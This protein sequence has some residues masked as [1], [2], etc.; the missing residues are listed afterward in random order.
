MSKWIQVL[1]F[2]NQKHKT[3]L[4]WW[5]V[6][7]DRCLFVLYMWMLENFSVRQNLSHFSDLSWL[8]PNRKT[9]KCWPRYHDRS[10]LQELVWGSTNLGWFQKSC[11]DLMKS[12]LLYHKYVFFKWN[13]AIRYC[14]EYSM[15]Y[16]YLKETPMLWKTHGWGTTPQYLMKGFWYK[17]LTQSLVS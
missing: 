2:H 5:T 7:Y 12:R 17:H 11:R 9:P 15:R 8:K 13:K 14:N 3:C 1:T 6:G 16:V 4:C 10:V